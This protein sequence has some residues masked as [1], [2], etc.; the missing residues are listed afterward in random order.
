MDGR[1][2]DFINKTALMIELRKE[3]VRDVTVIS[4]QGIAGAQSMRY[5]YTLY[6]EDKV[7]SFDLP[8]FQMGLSK[9]WN[10]HH[11]NRSIIIADTFEYLGKQG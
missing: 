8:M 9:L 11:K 1:Y 10:I 7:R 3:R 2:M 4:T 5:A 6:V